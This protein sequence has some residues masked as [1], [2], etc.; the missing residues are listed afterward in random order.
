MDPY[1]KGKKINLRRI[2][3]SDAES[4]YQYCKDRAVSRYTFIPHP[5]RIEDAH[6]FIRF[7]HRKFHAQTNYIL[8]M[9]HQETGK[10]IGTVSLDNVNYQH[11]NAELGYALA[12]KFWRQGIATEAVRLMLIFG[13]KELKL[14]RIYA[15]VMNPNIASIKLLE[16]CG[17]THEGTMR[18]MLFHLNQ[19]HDILWFGILKEEYKRINSRA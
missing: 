7:C 6:T 1:L 8:G 3:K 16:S 10:I 18:R 9:E 19:W 4:I 15:R 13:F 2:R 17:F 12:Q 14:K 5:Y 11:K